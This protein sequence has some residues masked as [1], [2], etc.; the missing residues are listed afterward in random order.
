MDDVMF[1]PNA[2]LP[3]ILVRPEEV[4]T[5]FAGTTGSLVCVANAEPTPTITWFRNG[6]EISNESFPG[7]IIEATIVNGTDE[8]TVLSILDVCPFQSQFSGNFSCTAL[9]FYGNQTVDFLIQ[10]ISGNC[11]CGNQCE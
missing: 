5:V 2:G 7:V 3:S 8:Q 1:L 11:I 9:N 10:V 6:M 4:V